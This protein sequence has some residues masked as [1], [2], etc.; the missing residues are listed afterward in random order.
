MM[1]SPYQTMDDISSKAHLVHR[2]LH[3]EIYYPEHSPRTESSAYKK[4]HDH[5]T[6]E[7]DLPCIVCGVRNSTLKDNKIGAKQIESHHHVVEWALQNAI[8]LQ[9]FNERVV[10]FHKVKNPTKYDH[11][12]TEQEMKDWI[13]HDPDNLWILC[14]VHHRHS[15]V[16][17]HSVTWPIWSP[18]DLIKDGYVYTP[19]EVI[20]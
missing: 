10:A 12:F 1:T 20:K 2:M 15:L 6:K 11:D 8:D 3:E 16:G 5:L 9:K 13:D 19:K 18:Q 4:V 14:D 17:I 7:L